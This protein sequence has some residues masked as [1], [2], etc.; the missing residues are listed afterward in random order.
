MMLR[1]LL[2]LEIEKLVINLNKKNLL[3]FGDATF[4]RPIA[5]FFRI[6]SRF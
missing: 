4:N 1:L 2:D 6:F 5:L 3:S